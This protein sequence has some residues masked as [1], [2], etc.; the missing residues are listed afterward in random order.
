MLLLL[1]GA[2]IFKNWTLLLTFQR[3]MLLPSSVL[4]KG[5]NTDNVNVLAESQTQEKW[6]EAGIQSRRPGTS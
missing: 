1:L 4:Q 3:S 6:G 5:D 2:G